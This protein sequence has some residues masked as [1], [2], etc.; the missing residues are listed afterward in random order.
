MNDRAPGFVAHAFHPGQGNEV[1]TGLI[2]VDRWHFHFQSE[3]VSLDIPLS[4]LE[5]REGEGEDERIYF[6]DAAMPGWEIFTTDASVLDHP[7]LA[8]A[9]NVREQL[10]GDASRQELWRR[11]RLVG[12]VLGVCAVLTWLGQLAVSAMARS[13]IARVPPEVEKKFGDEAMAE[14]RQELVFV[15]DSNRVANVALLAA[16]L[17]SSVGDGKTE[18]HFY[19]VENDDPNAFALPGGRVV[20][21][22]GL[23]KLVDRPEELLGVM[24]HELAH[25]TQRHGLR[26]AAASAGPILIFQIFL[27]GGG[28]GG[29]VTGAADLMV[30]QGFSQE[31]ELEADDVGWQMLVNANIDPRGMTDALTKLQQFEAAQKDKRDTVPQAFSSHPALDK[32]IARLEKKWEK[33]PRKIGFENVSG[34]DFALKAAAGK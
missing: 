7:I 2:L 21:T 15:E 5:V 28:V 18:L 13:L 10:S 3:T 34:A 8:Q 29:L 6:T 30:R 26:E 31:Y 1:A 12:Y 32:R 23:L 20:V 19:I 11:L 22:T 24:A 25:V 27:G 16:P 14:M 33:L 17:T 9:T 4:R